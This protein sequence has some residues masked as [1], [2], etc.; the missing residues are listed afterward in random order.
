MKDLRDPRL[1]WTKGVLFL[2][3]AAAAAG[4]LIAELPGWKT[5]LLLALLVWGSCRA[6]YFAFYVLERYADP[7]FRYS[8]L[9]SLLRYIAGSRRR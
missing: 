3:I 1:M 2:V 8:G 9:L 7:A 6:Y 4:L 5:V